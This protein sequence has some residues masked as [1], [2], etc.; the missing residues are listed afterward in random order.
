M[1]CVALLRGVNVG[2]KHRLPMADLAAIFSSAGAIDVRT[3][4]QSGNVL[5]EARDPREVILLV[6]EEILARFGFAAPCVVRSGLD[7]RAFLEAAPFSGDQLFGGFLAEAPEPDRL[8]LLDP[9]R[10]A[11]DEFAVVGSNVYLKIVTGAATTKLTTA[12]FDAKLNTTMTVRNWNT[13]R[14][15]AELAQ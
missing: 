4:I 7:L 6:E 11:P 2:G 9:L 13:I 14:A 5:F 15:L 3:F 8:A 1:R 10:G 12:Y